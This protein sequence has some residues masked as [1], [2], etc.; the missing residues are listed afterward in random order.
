MEEYIKQVEDIISFLDDAILYADSDDYDMKKAQKDKMALKYLLKR[1]KELE[2]ENERLN[3]LDLSNS[4]LIANMS[5]R[6]Y[7]DREK[8]KK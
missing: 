5:E 8:N 2:Q 1:Y 3:K 6:H 7:H 4:K